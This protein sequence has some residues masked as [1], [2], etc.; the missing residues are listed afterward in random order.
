MIIGTLKPTDINVPW[1]DMVDPCV[2]LA[3]AQIKVEIHAA[4]K[5]MAMVFE[6]NILL[7][8]YLYKNNFS[9]IYFFIFILLGR[10]FWSRQSQSSRI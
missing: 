8:Y 9:S 10:L 2:K 5:Y 7:Y 1:R 4:M 6:N 3:E